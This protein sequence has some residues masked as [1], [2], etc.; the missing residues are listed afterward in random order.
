MADNVNITAGSGVVI[1][2]ED[3][4]G[5]QYQKVKLTAKG[6]IE[7]ESIISTTALTLCRMLSF[8]LALSSSAKASASSIGAMES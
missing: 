7:E 3:E 6:S 1:A 5:V 2:S 8:T 4:G